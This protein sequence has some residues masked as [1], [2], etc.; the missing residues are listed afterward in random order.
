[1]KYGVMKG[2][3]NKRNIDTWINNLVVGKEALFDLKQ[4]VKVNNVE[5]WDGLDHKPSYTEE[6]L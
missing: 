5:K 6:D 4:L 1:M 3:F 2:A